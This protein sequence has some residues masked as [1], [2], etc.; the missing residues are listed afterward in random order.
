MTLK[1]KRK[2][3][4]IFTV[5]CIGCF[6]QGPPVPPGSEK[7]ELPIDGGVLIATFVAVCYGVKK[8]IKK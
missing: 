1:I 3:T 5:L 7:P 4:Y 6:A 2:I 8:I